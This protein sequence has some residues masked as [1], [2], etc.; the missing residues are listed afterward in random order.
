METVTSTIALIACPIVLCL[1]ALY[2]CYGLYWL[3]TV[4]Y[5]I[6]T[7]CMIGFHDC[8]FWSI[9]FVIVGIILILY[10]LTKDILK[11][12]F[13]ICEI[14]IFV[15]CVYYLSVGFVCDLARL[16]MIYN[17]LWLITI[18]IGMKIL[19]KI[20]LIVVCIVMMIFSTFVI[21]IAMGTDEILNIY[22]FSPFDYK[23]G[24]TSNTYVNV[25]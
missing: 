10:P 14:I 22:N 19:V 15:V 23:L 11:C 20:L 24:S 2:V 5:I 13:F 7:I 9:F 3:A 8:A 18:L 16:D 17:S 25:V 6:V 12:I 1:C 4:I 21:G